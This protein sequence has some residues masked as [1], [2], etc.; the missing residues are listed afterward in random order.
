[1]NKETR[2]NDGWYFQILQNQSL[3]LLHKEKG[4]RTEENRAS[5]SLHDRRKVSLTKNEEK[6]LT[7]KR[8]EPMDLN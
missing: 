1:M 7:K 6:R 3:G 2:E 8:L 5:L 4:K